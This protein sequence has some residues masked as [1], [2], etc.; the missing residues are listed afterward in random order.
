M[1]CI[2]YRLRHFINQSAN[3]GQFP[4]HLIISIVYKKMMFI[5]LK[6]TCTL[7]EDLNCW[8]FRFLHPTGCISVLSWRRKPWYWNHW[9]Y[10]HIVNHFWFYLGYNLYDW[11]YCMHYHYLK[12]VMHI[13]N[14]HLNLKRLCYVTFLNKNEV[15]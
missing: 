6:E 10:L 15:K 9:K 12:Q 3:K 5:N 8:I 13:L 2:L 11:N 1:S 4:C 14:I 7:N